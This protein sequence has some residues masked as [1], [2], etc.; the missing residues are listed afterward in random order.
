MTLI[1]KLFKE[2][3]YKFPSIFFILF[4]FIF[5]QAILNLAT[6]I[7][8]TPLIDILLQV[9]NVNKSFITKFFDNFF[10]YFNFNDDFRLLQIIVFISFVFIFTGI[11]G[12][13]VQYIVLVAQHKLLN[14]LKSNNL[15][16]FLHSK[17][18]FFSEENIGLLINSFQ[19]EINKISQAFAGIS[20]VAANLF[21]GIMFLSI[22]L[23]LSFKLTIYFIIILTIILSPMYFAKRYSYILGK[24]N[25][26][27]ANKMVSNLHEI[28]TSSKIIQSFSRHKDSLNNFNTSL[29]LHADASIK[30]QTFNRGIY[31]IIIPLGTIAALITLYISSFE[32]VKLSEMAMVFFAFSRILP[33]VGMLLQERN[34]IE[35]F[36]PAYEQ[37]NNLREKSDKY[38]ENTTGKKFVEL[39]KNIIFKN[40]YFS[41]PQRGKILNNI[42]LVFKKGN[43]TSLVGKS[44][45]GKST[46][47]DLLLGLHSVNSGNIIIDD[48]F[49]HNYNI[50]SFR[51]KIGYVPQEPFL[52]NMTIK[53]NILWSNPSLTDE[54]LEVVLK[55]SNCYEFVSKFPFKEN[56]ILGDRGMRLSGGQKQRISL[57]RAIARNP[58]ILILDEATSNL[59]SYSEDLIQKSIKELSSKMTVIIVSHRLSTIT[60]SDFVYVIDN[61]EVVE[62]GKYDDLIKHK[63]GIFYELIN[64]QMVLK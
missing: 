58:Q 7:A 37:I 32:N 44:G 9:D 55:T 19:T 57:A 48:N 56:T 47:L 3:F 23:F 4:L 20:R 60:L 10:Y 42:N 43:V 59:D 45:S 1:I 25:T 5:I 46:I 61:G 50:S 8:M 36:L 26:K 15:E 22:P 24:I 16:K 13:I 35:G 6:V 39:K 17:Q 29:D 40:I 27:T 62:E 14:Y 49:Y 54:M 51:D 38:S 21:Q 34:N 12:I 63:K 31:L 52:F 53:E 11:A 28:L 18:T 64:N 33:V 41:Y 2:I 30:Y